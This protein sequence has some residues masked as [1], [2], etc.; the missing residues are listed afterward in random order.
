MDAHILEKVLG[1]TINVPDDAVHMEIYMK[2]I[3]T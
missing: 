3:V 2:E 1:I